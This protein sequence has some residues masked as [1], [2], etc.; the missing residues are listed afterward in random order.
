MILTRAEVVELTG[1][2][3]L[4]HGAYWYVQGGKWTR[5]GKTLAD[6]LA[7]KPLARKRK[8]GRAQ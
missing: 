2:V 3:Y 6:A 4:R 8:K 7:A 5:L 1:R